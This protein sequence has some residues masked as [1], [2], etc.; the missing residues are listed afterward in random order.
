MANF[1]DMFIF[2]EFK[3]LWDGGQLCLDSSGMWE[4]GWVSLF[5][6]PKPVSLFCL[7]KAIIKTPKNIFI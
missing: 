7:E 3:P 4:D 1:Y 6:K 2:K 5:L